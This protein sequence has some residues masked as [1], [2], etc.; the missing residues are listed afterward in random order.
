MHGDVYFKVLYSL[1]HAYLSDLMLRRL[2]QLHFSSSEI[3][4]KITC[5]DDVFQLKDHTIVLQPKGSIEDCPT[6]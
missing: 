4:L 1:G 5:A 2:D 6:V 3:I